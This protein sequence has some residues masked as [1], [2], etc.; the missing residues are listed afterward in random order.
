MPGHGEICKVRLNLKYH[1]ALSFF[2]PRTL[3]CKLCDEYH[4]KLHDANRL[5]LPYPHLPEFPSTA[6]IIAKAEE[7]KKFVDAA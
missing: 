1:L 6:D 5:T 4:A 3:T 2:F 7:L